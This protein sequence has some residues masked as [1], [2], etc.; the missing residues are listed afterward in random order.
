[1]MIAHL[2]KAS[3][4]DYPGKIASMLFCPFC[5]LRC[6]FCHNPELCFFKG[7]FVNEKD[8]LSFLESRIGKIEAVV[9]TGGEPTLQ[10]DL[11][12]FINKVKQ[13]GY[14]VKLDTNAHNPEALAKCL[15]LADVIAIDL[16]L[17][18]INM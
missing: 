12:D 7:D 18:V 5:N 9:I 15:D 2:Q 3:F 10:D 17:L 16:K 13:I 4:I 8:V 14:L 6:P 11:P 1:M